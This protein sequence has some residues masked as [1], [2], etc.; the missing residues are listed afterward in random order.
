MDLQSR[1]LALPG[2]IEI[3]PTRW[4]DERGFFSETYS[5]S[6]FSDIGIDI[7][8]VQDNHSYSQK[9][10]VVRGLHFQMPPFAQDKLVWVTCGRVLDVVVDIRLGSPSFGQWL[11]VEL[12]A[13]KWN[14]LFI[15]KGFAH[16]YSTLEPDTELLY[17]VSAPYSPDHDRAIRYDDPSIG[18]DWGL[19][20]KAPLVSD[21]DDCAPL[22][23]DTDTGFVCGQEL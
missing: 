22:L 14:Q 16:G 2:I 18:I 11:G 1:A 17:K 4:N 5:R 20:G 15:P 23:R 3:T 21:K 7:V 13:E 6:D 19:G 12:S 9:A 10:G 8:W